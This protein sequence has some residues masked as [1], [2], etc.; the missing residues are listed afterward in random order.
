MHLFLPALHLMYVDPSTGGL[1]FQV[2]GFIFAT[3]SG[4]LFYFSRQAKLA[5]ARLRRFFTERLSRS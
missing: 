1:V 3:I 5:A 2:L 4:A